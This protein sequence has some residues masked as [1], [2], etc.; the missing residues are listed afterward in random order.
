MKSFKIRRKKG[1]EHYK[2]FIRNKLPRPK[3]P[4][5]LFRHVHQ[6]GVVPSFELEF[7]TEN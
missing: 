5:R 3:A 7:N 2:I 6:K 1:G 4:L